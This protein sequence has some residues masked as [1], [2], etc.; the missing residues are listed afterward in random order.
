MLVVKMRWYVRGEVNHI[1]MLANDLVDVSGEND[2]LVYR[3]MGEHSTME[4][5]QLSISICSSNTTVKYKC[6]C[7]REENES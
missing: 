4:V 6:T 3:R 1:A 7:K 5:L 2:K